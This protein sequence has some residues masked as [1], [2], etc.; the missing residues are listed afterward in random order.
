MTDQVGDSGD[1][2]TGPLLDEIAAIRARAEA[3][4]VAAEEA[5]RKANSEAGFAFNAKQQCE[6]HA[7]AIAR[8]KGTVEA[9]SNWLT[10][11]KQ[12]AEAA[13]SAI[14]A[15]RTTAE[16]DARAA[17]ESRGNANSEL[18]LVRSSRE[19][20][21]GHLAATEKARDEA[22]A[23]A[24]RAG[25]DLASVTQS[26]ATTD[27]D[28]AAVQA[29]RSQVSEAA[30]K[31]QADGQSIASKSTESQTLVA[32]LVE[33][34]ETSKT[35]HARVQVYEGQLKALETQ[36]QELHR[37]IEAL[38]PGATSAGLASAFRDQRDRFD[39]PQVAWLIVF[40][41]AIVLLIGAGAYRL[42][43]L[44]EGELVTWDSILRHLVNRVPLI[45]PLVWLA[46]F[47]G[48]NYTMALRLQE[49]Y[50]YKEAISTSF[51]GYRREMG[52]IPAASEQSS[53]LITL[54]ENVLA[55]LSQRPGRLYEGKHED[56]TPLTPLKD[57]IKDTKIMEVLRRL[58]KSG[59][60]PS[61]D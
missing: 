22:T 26:K 40:I 42:P 8:V 32:T 41:L 9:D 20:A 36:C 58:A 11:A 6:E 59:G 46:L 25:E 57:L 38:L 48:R 44:A 7:T 24:K 27:A 61:A 16:A 4:A 13:G 35:T 12:N 18:E 56:L 23:A 37:K 33:V 49:D 51:E 39:R 30:A 3:A 55:T 14:A 60:Q 19:K 5:S 47:A 50:A 21:D 2:S 17:S 54:S 52:G 34:T 10:T 45:A 29:L 53:P 1:G 28:A 15:A 31:A 43:G